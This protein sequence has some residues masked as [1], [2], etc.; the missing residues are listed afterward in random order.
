MITHNISLDMLEPGIP[1]RIQV[2][3][4]DSMSRNVRITPKIF[5]TFPFS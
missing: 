3:Q 4:G 1:P 5:A 2:K